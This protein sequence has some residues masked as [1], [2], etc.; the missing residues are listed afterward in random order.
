[1]KVL[2]LWFEAIGVSCLLA[3]SFR[4]KGLRGLGQEVFK[5]F[6]RLGWKASGR[7]TPILGARVMVGYY[8]VIE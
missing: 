2:R 8:A 1:M 6:Q 4:L 5:R 3:W 7:R